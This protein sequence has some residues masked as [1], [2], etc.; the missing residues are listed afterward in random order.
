MPELLTGRYCHP[1]A[2]TSQLED[3]MA[4]T[5]R[6]YQ[7]RI[8]PAHLVKKETTFM[9]AS[10][11]AQGGYAGRYSICPQHHVRLASEMSCFLFSS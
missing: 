1:A 9:S 6:E 11:D 2:R 4:G 3:F 8:S 10:P 5:T 7:M